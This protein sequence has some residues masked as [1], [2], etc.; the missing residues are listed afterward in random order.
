MPI[1]YERDGRTVIVHP[2]PGVDAEQIAATVPEGIE[3]RIV[4]EEEVAAII[5]AEA[6]PLAPAPPAISDRQFFQALALDGYIT[7]A[8]ALAAVRTGALPPVLADL[9]DHMDGDERFGAEMLLS[10]A[11]EF[12][13]DHPMTVAIGEARGMTPIEVDDFFRRAAAL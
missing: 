8:E 13:R 4:S 12:R 9:L 6:P 10:G 1:I 7:Q 11:T 5:A 3:W 2:A